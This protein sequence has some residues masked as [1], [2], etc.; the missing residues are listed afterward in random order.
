ME[1]PVLLCQLLRFAESSYAERTLQGRMAFQ[2]RIV[3]ATTD[4]LRKSSGVAC[5]G[6][7]HPAAA[8]DAGACLVGKGRPG[9]RPPHHLRRY[10]KNSENYV[11]WPVSAA[12]GL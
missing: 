11:A 7:P 8:V 6:C 4:S 2:F 3:S 9:G 12:D 5:N 1:P 10:P